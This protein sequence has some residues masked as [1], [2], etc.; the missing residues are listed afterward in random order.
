[1]PF[2]P[3]GI[4][5][6]LALAALAGAVP[7]AGVEVSSS[8]EPPVIGLGEVATFSVEAHATGFDH[9]RF[10]PSFQVE[11]FE[12][13]AGPF[14]SESVNFVNGLLSRSFR[15]SWQLRPLVVGRA[16]V[17]AVALHLQDQTLELPA[18]EITVQKEPLAPAA[19]G[20]AAGGGG[21]DEEQEPSDPFDRLFGRSPL[22]Q[23]FAPRQP[24]TEAARVFVRAE[25][26]PDHPYAGQETL[27]TLCL[28]THDEIS[29]INQA[30]VPSFRGFWVRDIPQPQ[31]LTSE[32]VEINGERYAR[33]VLL[34]K[35][36]FPLRP[37]MLA[38]EPIDVEVVARGLASSFFGTFEQPRQIR[39][40]APEVQIDVR[41]LPPAPPGWN[42]AVGR[43]ALAADLE[44]KDLRLGDAATLNVTLTGDGHLQGVPAP[45]I[46]APPGL[47]ILAPQQQGEDGLSGTTVRGRRAWSFPVVPRRQGRFRLA[48]PQIPYFDPQA[49][50]YRMASAPAM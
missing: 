18:S 43:F 22:R 35:A 7:A 21:Q 29:G 16:R 41:P 15:L 39:L 30:S 31:N 33:V 40:R 45:A 19:P 8:L 25:V 32:M 28:Y 17:K 4:A 13:V 42:G 36:L 9:L 37:G 12:I 20:A 46:A 26:A 38:V 5:V 10:Q 3:T 47:T 50:Q 27:Y 14:Q 34:R 11:N 2:R 6:Y 44:P 48:V 24:R 49:G 23:L 1:M